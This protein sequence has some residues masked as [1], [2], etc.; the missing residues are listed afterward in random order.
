MNRAGAR[1]AENAM[2]EGGQ[3]SFKENV[4]EM[5]KQ[6]PAIP[7]PPSNERPRMLSN[8][9]DR[10]AFKSGAV[11]SAVVMGMIAVLCWGGIAMLD[12]GLWPAGAVLLVGGLP[13]AVLA[14]LYRKAW[15]VGTVVDGGGP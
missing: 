4:D 3:S 9:E 14:G 10:W 15:M 1:E 6:S 13:I 11:G 2:T 8:A 7:E 5:T 12:M